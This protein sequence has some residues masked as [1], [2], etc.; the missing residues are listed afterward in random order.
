M[1]RV[2]GKAE[3]RAEEGDHL[4]S[5]RNRQCILDRGD[6]TPNRTKC[7]VLGM[8]VGAK[9]LFMSKGTYIHA[10]HKQIPRIAIVVHFLRGE[11]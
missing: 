11:D 3:P 4:R 9:T 1:D 6:I 2:E 5:Y 8:G 10:T 7:V